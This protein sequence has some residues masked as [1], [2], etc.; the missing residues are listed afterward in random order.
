MCL[1]LATWDMKLQHVQL[2]GEGASTEGRGDEVLETEAEGAAGPRERLLCRVVG[3]RVEGTLS[4][5]FPSSLAALKSL[6]PILMS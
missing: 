5:L 1:W 6:S 3:S 2:R 4:R